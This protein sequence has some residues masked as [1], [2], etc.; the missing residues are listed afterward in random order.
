MGSDSEAPGVRAASL[1]SFGQHQAPWPTPRWSNIGRVVLDVTH[2]KPGRTPFNRNLQYGP[3]AAPVAVSTEPPVPSASSSPLPNTPTAAI[4][5]APWGRCGQRRP[6]RSR[7]RAARAPVPV[8][9]AP[10][11]GDGE[12]YGNLRRSAPVR[13]APLTTG[14]LHAPVARSAGADRAAQRAHPFAQVP[15]AAV[16]WPVRAPRG[17]ARADY[18]QLARR[19]RPGSR[20]GTSGRQGFSLDKT[21]QKALSGQKSR[22]DSLSGSALRPAS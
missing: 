6:A 16:S 10:A 13:V 12:V 19:C 2:S 14:R 15:S 9:A 5:G 3:I 7:Q 8:P 11:P 20:G 1:R 21:S 22:S 18:R 17:L 4:L